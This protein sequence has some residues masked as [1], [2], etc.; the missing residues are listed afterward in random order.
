MRMKNDLKIFIKNLPFNLICW[1]VL[2]QGNM[3]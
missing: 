1:D 2:S 3:A